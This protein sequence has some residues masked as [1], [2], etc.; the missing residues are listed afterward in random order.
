LP[1][2]RRVCD[3]L[4]PHNKGAIMGFDALLFVNIALGIVGGILAAA[5]LI[6]S[7]KPNAKAMIDKLTPF[8]ALIGVGM[9]AISIINFFRMLG[10]FTSTL[11]Y[12]PLLG[13]SALAMLGS[14]V[15]L[16]ALFGMPQIAK[17]VPGESSAEQKALELSKKVAPYQV[18]L[19]IIAIVSSLIMMLYMFRIL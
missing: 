1:P 7:K 3:T 8:Q 11:K 13:A 15:L 19:G 2:A 12:M 6:V 4:D 5:T 17:W 16:G 9:V 18:M 10:G 14:G